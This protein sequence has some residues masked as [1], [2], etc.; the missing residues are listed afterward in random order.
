MCIESGYGAAYLDESC[1]PASFSSASTTT[2]CVG[3]SWPPLA[4]TASAHLP[5]FLQ[6]RG[7]GCGGGEGAAK[8]GASA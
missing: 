6:R 5:V 4:Q 3:S 8:G 1:F 7:N 2:L